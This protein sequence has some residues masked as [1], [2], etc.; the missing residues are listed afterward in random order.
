VSG[1][2]EVTVVDVQRALRCV[3]ASLTGDEDQVVHAVVEA[4]RDKATGPLAL[5]VALA[6]VG[7][8][9]EREALGDEAVDAV[10]LKLLGL[11]EGHDNDE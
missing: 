1:D 7:A 9:S 4:A 8:Q 2:I 3:L 11:T 5:I 6:R 10:T